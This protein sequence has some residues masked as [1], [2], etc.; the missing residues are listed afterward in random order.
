MDYHDIKI[1]ELLDKCDYWHAQGISYSNSTD[2][3]REK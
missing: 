2:Y 3:R 1:K